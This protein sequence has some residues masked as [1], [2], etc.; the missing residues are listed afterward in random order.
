MGLR[1]QNWESTKQGRLAG[2][3]IP[4]GQDLSSQ[5]CNHHTWGHRSISGEPGGRC[6]R[7]KQKYSFAYGRWEGNL[8]GAGHPECLQY[9][10][11]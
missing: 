1:S 3:K 9:K 6:E 5:K 10:F 2:K 11:R 7:N 4:R 8:K